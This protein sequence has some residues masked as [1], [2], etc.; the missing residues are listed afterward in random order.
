MKSTTISVV[1]TALFLLAWNTEADEKSSEPAPEF[2]ELEFWIGT[3]ETEGMNFDSVF[4]PGGTF[5]SIES[6]AWFDDEHFTVVCEWSED[7]GSD[8]H[9]MTIV[10]YG[11][12]EGAHTIYNFGSGLPPVFFTGSKEGNVWTFVEASDEAGRYTLEVTSPD[13]YSYA[14]EY[15]IGDGDWMKASEGRARKVR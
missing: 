5:Q 10:S 6:C 4:G 12:H 15:K 2:R 1:V 14:F 11:M 8:V 3:W 9:G 13:T 7:E